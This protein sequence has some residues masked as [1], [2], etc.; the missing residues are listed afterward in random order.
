VPLIA[1]LYW[2]LAQ[3]GGHW[4]IWALLPGGLLFATGTAMLL[5]PGESR[6]T[7]LMALGALLGVLLFP[8]AWL[9]ADFGVALLTTIGS[10][11]SFLVAGRLGLMR[12]PLYEGAPPPEFNTV[13][14]AK[15]AL[16][17]AVVGY[18]LASASIP[19]GSA[20]AD[21]CRET[22]ELEKVLTERAYLLDP[23]GLHPAP[24][25]P[26][27]IWWKKGQIY[28][29]QYDVLRF[30]SGYEPADLPGAGKWKG[31]RANRSCSVRMLRHPGPPRPWLLC[32]HGYRMGVP[33]LDFSLFSP[34]WL[35]ERLGLNLLMPVLPLHGPRREGLRSG[36]SFLD[37]NI[38][39]LV[40][41]EAQSLW[42][43]RRTLAWLRREEANARV[44]VLGFSL[45]GY[46]AA[47]LAGYEPALEFVVAG[48]PAVDF[49]ELLW[50][51]LPRDHKRYFAAHGI[52]EARY[53]AMLG[54]V[55]P[56][57]RPPTVAQ[58]RLLIFAGTGDR[59][60]V[61]SQPLRLARH[62]GVPVNWYQGAHLTVRREPETR[63]TLKEAMLRAGWR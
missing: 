46:N 43:L 63:D 45:G 20:A 44:G 15:A 7:A 36:D 29:Y 26:E 52:T 9:L 11:L 30:D 8:I 24:P 60:V 57:A 12:E 1:G 13:L 50:R 49:A 31:H 5:M 40:F 18:F 14:D 39:E 62:W 33:L 38:P 47:L 19:S 22:L 21:T 35:H 2:L 41:A 10:G 32:I 61:P 54:V 59:L 56:L 55:S 17:E 25:A 58:D 37:G 48:I 53:R 27:K 28:G 3:G 16:D 34:A 51:H 42:D 4:L 23:S 6:V